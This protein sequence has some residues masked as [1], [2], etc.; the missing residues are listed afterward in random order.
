MT[1]EGVLFVSLPDLF[2]SPDWLGLLGAL[3]LP[4]PLSLFVMVFGS[5]CLDLSLLVSTLAVSAGLS[6]AA[7]LGLLLGAPPPKSISSR[8]FSVLP[9]FLPA[10]N[11]EYIAVYLHT[12]TWVFHHHLRCVILF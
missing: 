7:G 9:F 12:N 10:S 3:G 4:D 2:I 5:Y 11:P 6:C 1:I 8:A